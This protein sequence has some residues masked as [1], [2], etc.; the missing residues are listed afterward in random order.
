MSLHEEIN[1]NGWVIAKNVFN[2]EEINQFRE[3]AL[4]DTNHK[5]DLLSS[6]TLSEVITDKRLLDIIKECLGTESLFYF[7]DSSVSINVRN[8]GFH[9]DSRDRENINSPEFKDIDYSLLR[10]GIY[11]QDHTKHSKGLSLKDKS[12]LIP[13]ISK[14]KIINV[15]SEVGDVIIWK[16][17][18]THSANADI[19]SL[20][21]N[22]D[23]NPKITKMIPNIFKLKA[24]D[25][26]IA[27][28][29]CF[30][31]QDKY[32]ESYIDYLKTRAY[33]VERWKESTYTNE[34]ILKMKK[35]DVIVD[36]SFDVKDINSANVHEG[37]V[38][39]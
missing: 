13:Q 39:L 7:G 6:K 24:I 18:T 31:K 17:T 29:A 34:N 21:P 9:K 10:I 1:K 19:L 26:R 12:H 14:G 2:S 23:L 5:G 27:F 30:G 11:L 20:F 22:L 36:T 8:R 38:Q 33:A 25:P 32:S 3:W 28:F 35:N 15:K 37:Y 16:L 4:N